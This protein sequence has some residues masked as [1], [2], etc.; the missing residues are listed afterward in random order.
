VPLGSLKW[1]ITREFR[2]RAAPGTYQFRNLRLVQQAAERGHTL[3]KG[4][5][6]SQEGVL[7][8]NSGTVRRPIRA[9]LADSGL[10]KRHRKGDTLKKGTGTSRQ[11]VLVGIQLPGF[12]ASPL[13]QEASR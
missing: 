4:T 12:G 5:G 7:V 9:D 6:T 11:S 8:G 3:Q 2:N 10:F 1:D 13:F